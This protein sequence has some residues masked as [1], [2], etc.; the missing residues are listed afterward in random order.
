MINSLQVY[1]KSPIYYGQPTII[2]KSSPQPNTIYR[3]DSPSNNNVVVK[4]LKPYSPIT[5][6]DKFKDVPKALVYKSKLSF[7]SK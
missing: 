2:T 7:T 3:V 5:R 6:E 1:Q 4:S